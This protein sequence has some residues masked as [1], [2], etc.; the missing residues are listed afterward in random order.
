MPKKQYTKRVSKLKKQLREIDYAYYV[1]DK[2]IVSDAVRDSLKAE[3]EQLENAHTDLITAD[4]PTQRIGGKALGKFKRVK[5]KIPKY[6]LEDVF[7]WDEVVEF[8][9]KIKRFLKLDQTKKIA[10][11]CEMKIDGLNISCIYKKGLFYQA[12]TRGDGQVGEDVT[13]T[14]KTIASLPLKL[15]QAVDIEVGGEIFMPIDSFKKLNQYAKKNNQTQFANPRNAAAG[16]IRQ[17]DPQVA[18][19]RDLHIY[20]YSIS[21]PSPFN[22]GLSSQFKLLQYLQ[23][24][25]LPVER[26][27]KV[28]DSAD[29]IK[30]Y[31]EKVAQQREKLN[32]E[33]DGVVAKVSSLARQ[34][35]L[36][37]TAKTVRW[38]VAYKFSAEQATTVVEDI[39]VQVG[40]TGALTPVAHLKSTKVAGSTVSR[41]TLHNQ[42]EIN[43]LDVRVGDTV[44]IQKAG[45]VIPDIV[46]V[47]PKMRSGNEKKYYLPSNCPV[48]GSAIQKK[49][50]EA[51]YRCSN[52]N[53]FAQNKEKLYHLVSR[54]AFNIDG[55]GPNIIDQLLDNALIKD[56]ADIFNLKQGDLEPLEGFAEKSA[57]NLIQAIQDSKKIVLHRFVFSLGIRNV[58]Q[59]TALDLAKFLY[60]RQPNLNHKNFMASI[61]AFKADDFEQVN[62]IG[63]VVA[64]SIYDYF[65]DK[66]HIDLIKK[67]FNSGVRLATTYL[68]STAK[69]GKLSNQT[70]VLTGSLNHFTRQ[71]AKEKIQQLGGYVAGQISN[72]TGYLVSGANP[73]SKYERAKQLGVNILDE[74]K[75]MDMVGGG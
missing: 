71:Q 26:S 68:S 53:C 39:Q 65:Q 75:F 2:P 5:H 18:A 32:F 10:Y 56:A 15:R 33:I 24:L 1:L 63:P 48:C 58:G 27:F 59:Q 64:K 42:N 20:F 60:H 54:P 6:S 57:Q 45:D 74:K 46:K 3:L 17:L 21:D 44:V 16:T 66:R 28:V 40:R 73:G 50:G 38:A 36:G 22:L 37:R 41:A 72:K 35:E 69:Q 11:T 7:L 67:M 30:G 70:F 29:E 47:L 12:I 19:N 43:R 23:H 4:S 31:F 25:G 61:T 55:L 49:S 8:D 34:Q 9:K 51:V 14:V 52:P 13:H 62:D